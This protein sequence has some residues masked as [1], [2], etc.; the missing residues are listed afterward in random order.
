MLFWLYPGVY[1]PSTSIIL[2]S[3]V[4][5]YALAGNSTSIIL[6]SFVRRTCAIY[7][8]T[9]NSAFGKRCV[10][11]GYTPNPLYRCGTVAKYYGYPLEFISYAVG[12]YSSVKGSIGK[13]PIK[14]DLFFQSFSISAFFVLLIIQAL[15][16][17]IF[18]TSYPC[19]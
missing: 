6:G 3:P 1:T 15:I 16:D 13:R 11:S 18:T 8:V 9:F 2:Y 19:N 12:R 17:C 4:Y 7:S 5:S 14:R 10:Q